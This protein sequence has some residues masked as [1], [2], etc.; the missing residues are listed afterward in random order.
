[1]ELPRNW[2]TYNFINRNGESIWETDF[3]FLAVH[4]G[5]FIGVSYW[6]RFIALFRAKQYISLQLPIMW[7]AVCY[8][9]WIVNHTITQSQN[10]RGW[11]GSQEIIE[12]NPLLKQVPYS[13]S[14]RSWICPYWDSFWATCSVLYH[15]YRKAV[16]LCVSMELP[17][18][19]LYAI[20]PCPITHTTENS[21]ASFICLPPPFRYL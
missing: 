17:M 2:D 10:S 4:I 13:K 14:H 21:P 20:T 6:V 19:K 3:F 15:P 12:S 16:L 7:N 1:M 11:R 5:C 8:S 9:C 18:Y